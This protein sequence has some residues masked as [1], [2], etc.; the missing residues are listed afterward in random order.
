MRKIIHRA[1]VVA[2]G[3]EEDMTNLCRTLLANCDMLETPDDRPPY[4]LEEL[5]EQIYRESA[6]L[7]EGE[8]G[9][10]Y[11][12]TAFQS[13]GDAVEGS[14][15]LDIKCHETGMWMASFRYESETPFQREDWLYLHEHA[16]RVPMLSIHACEE[17]AADKG[18]TIFS[19]GQVMDDWS[20]MGEI[21]LWLMRQY[22]VGN[23]PEEAVKALEQVER[24]MQE[25]DF[26]QTMPELLQGCI[27]HLRDIAAHTAQPEALSE[28][29]DICREKK[30]FQ[31][32]FMVQCRIAETL[33]WDM[34]RQ[35]LWLAN[36][37]STL[38]AWQEAHPA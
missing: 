8:K 20:L 4:S 18:M 19:G 37:E 34:A 11:G 26:D 10:Y 27:D 31:G 6:A 1:R 30:D 22:E 29:M 15:H 14:C 35:D 13:D 16:G 33:L 7:G 25:S 32:L 12:M 2:I 9:F 23:P 28:L 5:L 24:I 17:F 3:T 38:H 36:L 21:W